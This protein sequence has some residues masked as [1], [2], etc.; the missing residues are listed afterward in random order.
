MLSRGTPPNRALK[1][2]AKG[3][4]ALPGCIRLRCNPAKVRVADVRGGC[5]EDGAVKG[6]EQLAA[7][8]KRDTLGNAET[9]EQ[10]EV[11]I[12]ETGIAQVR[13]GT[14]RCSQAERPGSGKGGG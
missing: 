7:E 10:S 14:R 9:L 12:E 4:L 13:V 1:V 2:E 6:V 3:Q 11:F 8:G 5:T